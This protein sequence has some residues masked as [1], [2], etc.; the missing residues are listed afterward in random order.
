MQWKNKEA[1]NGADEEQL[2]WLE[3]R[4]GRKIGPDNQQANEKS[5]SV[6][7]HPGQFSSLPTP[8]GYLAISRVTFVCNKSEGGGITGVYWVEA[9]DATKHPTKHRTKNYLA[10]NAN[11]APTEKPRSRGY[12]F[13][14]EK[15]KPLTQ[16][17]KKALQGNLLTH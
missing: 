2:T 17:K 1:I 14:A 8:Q 4:Y 7:L 10:P 11:G 3:H 15:S 13:P 16:I 6:D 12:T 5:R 9:R